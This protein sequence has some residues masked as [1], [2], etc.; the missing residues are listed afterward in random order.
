MNLFEEY[1]WRGIVHTATEETEET[2]TD[3][4]VNAYIGFDPTA[5]S[6]HI[7]SLLPM[8]N[9]ARLQRFGHTPIAIVG[10]G[11]GLIGD[12]SGKTA[13]R[14]IL[15]KEKIEENLI[16]IR[17]QLSHL[18]D[19]DAKFNPALMINNADWLTTISITD[20]LRDIGKYFTVNFL[21]AKET[22]KRRLDQ[23]DGISFTEFSYLLLQAF[24]Y[25]MLYDKYN[26]TLQMGGSDQWGNITSGIDL[27]RKLRQGKAHGLVF[28]LVTT[29]TGTKFGKTE[30]GTIWL[31]PQMTSPFR[32]YQF[33]LNTDDRD[34]INYLKY[35]TWLNQDRIDELEASLEENPGQ[36]AA[37][38]TLAEEVTKMVHG[39]TELSKAENATKILFGSEI[40]DVTVENL[41]EI[42]TDVPS[43][44]VSKETLLGDGVELTELLQS[45]GIT[46]SKGEAKRLIKAGGIYINNRRINEVDRKLSKDDW[47]EGKVVIIRRG[48]K[49][50]HLINIED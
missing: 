38:K 46:G 42:F 33:W 21:L 35:F 40:V 5:K 6:L 30:A 22:I 13:E 37:H 26:C 43:T 10:G 15:S 14:Q 8:M 27:I 4:K 3:G 31:D 16:G 9:L 24:D 44:S 12:P 17:A 36:R 39:E 2:L 47:I 28:P 32:F 25:L 48:R 18:L 11:T 23:Q 50:Y 41:F 7:G 20:F 49:N 1:T 34:V 29:S 19:F 45:A